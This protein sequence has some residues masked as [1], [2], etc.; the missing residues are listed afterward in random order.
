MLHYFDMLHIAT[1]LLLCY[2]TLIFYIAWI[3]YTM[4]HCSKYSYIH[5]IGRVVR[6]FR[7]ALDKFYV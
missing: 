7:H 3:C 1:L 6:R 5:T 2:T 4:L